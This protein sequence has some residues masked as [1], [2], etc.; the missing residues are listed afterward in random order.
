MA[1][2]VIRAPAPSEVI[3]E[4]QPMASEVIRDHQRSSEVIRSHQRGSTDGIRGHQRSSTRLN[5][6][7]VYG[8]QNAQSRGNHVAKQLAITC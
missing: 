5:P 7:D 2:E 3:I 6:I 8:T 4:A 1:S